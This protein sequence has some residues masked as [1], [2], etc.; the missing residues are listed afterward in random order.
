MSGENITAPSWTSLPD[1]E[2]ST[3][4]CPE[5]SEFAT[6]RITDLTGGSPRTRRR[7]GTARG[8]GCGAKWDCV[9]L[10][11]TD[12]QY[13]GTGPSCRRV[14]VSLQSPFGETELESVL[15]C[16]LKRKWSVVSFVHPT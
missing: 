12:H 5:R 7:T 3:D 6:F 9:C 8:V 14:L 16:D 2:V 4:Y 15:D 10:K 13:D 11:G 1:A